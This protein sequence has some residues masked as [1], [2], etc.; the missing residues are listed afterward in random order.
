MNSIKVTVYKALKFL[1]VFSVV[2]Q[3]YKRQVLI[4]CYHGGSLG[5]EWSYNPRLFMRAE[6]FRSRIKILVDNGYSFIS[7]DDLVTKNLADLPIKS[8]CITFDDGW[9]STFTELIPVLAEHN[10]PST[11]YLHTQK[12]VDQMPLHNVAVRYLVS[13]ARI[14]FIDSNHGLPWQDGDYDIRVHGDVNRLILD[15]DAWTKVNN[16]TKG[17]VYI[18]LSQLALILDAQGD[19]VEF[20]DGRFDYLSTDQARLLPSLNC[21]IELHGHRHRYPI[22]DPESFNQDL[23]E[24]KKAIL[25]VGSDVPKHY[26]YP[27]GS[28][29]SLASPVLREHNVISATTCIPGFVDKKSLAAPHYLPRFLDGED[30]SE[31]EFLA[32]ISGT[33]DVF[34]RVRRRL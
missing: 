15:L 8:I 27:S 7:L 18:L 14:N 16:L 1:G 28:H 12:F 3:L 23:L 5:D 17:E 2:S 6:T 26:C 10:I 34:R 29:D 19:G 21:K 20:G 30:V 4:L 11:L 33:S 31:I 22:G 25:D 32:E 9:K 24:C 13:K